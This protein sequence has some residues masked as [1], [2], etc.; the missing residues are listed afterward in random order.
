M[1]RALDSFVRFAQME[2]LKLT[3][4]LLDWNKQTLTREAFSREACEKLLPHK[5]IHIDALYPGERKK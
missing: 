2:N 3:Q 4:T 5:H 1:F